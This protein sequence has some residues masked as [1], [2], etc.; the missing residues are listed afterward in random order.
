MTE[1]HNAMMLRTAKTFRDVLLSGAGLLALAL[2]LAPAT[3]SAQDG[4]PAPVTYTGQDGTTTT[5]AAHADGMAVSVQDAR[6]VTTRFNYD[7]QG[8]LLSEDAP[9]RGLTAYGYDEA[10]RPV[11]V[12]RPDGLSTRIHYDE[13]GRVSREVWRQDGAEAIVTRYGYDACANGEARLCRIVHNGHVTRYAYTED[14]QL[15]AINANLADEPDTETLRYAYNADGTLATLRYPSGLKL[16]Y[17]Y[18][19][20][21]RVSAITGV[22]ETGPDTAEGD[23]A[24]FTVVRGITY[25]ADGRVTG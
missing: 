18:D 25:D 23:R 13:A 8:R 11:R 6:G 17:A 22:Y 14:G 7:A 24:R 16:R 10:G 5:L 15:A 20:E 12:D 3:A 2:P 21:G 19:S 1:T 9:E 4:P